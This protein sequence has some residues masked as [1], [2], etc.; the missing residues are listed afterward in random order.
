MSTRV[1]VAGGDARDAWLCRFLEDQGYEVKSFGFHVEGVR[2]FCPKDA[3]LNIFIGPMTGID[4]QGR[5]ETV[6]GEGVLSSDILHS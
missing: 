4:A 6:D 2:A 5:M 1:V 3:P